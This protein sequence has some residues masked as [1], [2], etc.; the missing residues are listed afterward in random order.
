MNT[1]LGRGFIIK[2][3]SKVSLE[4]GRSGPRYNREE[5][6]KRPGIWAELLN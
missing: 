3:N 6:S 4:R 1:S 2:Y 5:E